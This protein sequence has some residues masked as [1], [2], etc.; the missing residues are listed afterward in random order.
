MSPETRAVLDELDP[1]LARFEAM[2]A[3]Q[4][5]I[6]DDARRMRAE[7]LRLDRR[8]AYHEREAGKARAFLAEA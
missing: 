6:L 7:L 1:T 8:V 3:G 4:Q 2:I 5:Q